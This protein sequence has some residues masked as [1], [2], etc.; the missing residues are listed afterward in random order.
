MKISLL[1]EM[2]MASGLTQSNGESERNAPHDHHDLDFDNNN[3]I[4]KIQHLNNTH[5]KKQKDRDFS[6]NRNE[7]GIRP[8]IVQLR[9]SAYSPL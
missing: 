5:Q 7:H 4:V 6:V 3:E 2:S 8:D 9:L 1:I